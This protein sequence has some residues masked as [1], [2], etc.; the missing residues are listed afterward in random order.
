M[1]VVP[2]S[3][4]VADLMT[5]CAPARLAES[6]VVSRWRPIW[7]MTSP[8]KAPQ[9]AVLAVGIARRAGLDSAV[10]RDAFSVVML[11]HVGCTAFAHEEAV[12]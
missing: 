5:D 3:Q 2:R 4:A 6:S 10:L 12:L 11:R 8:E 9:T 7:P 1:V